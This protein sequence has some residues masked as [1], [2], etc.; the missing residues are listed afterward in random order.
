MALAAAAAV[1]AA[2]PTALE[3]RQDFFDRRP[4]SVPNRILK[5]WVGAK[6]NGL[7]LWLDF[8][9]DSMLVVSDNGPRIYPVNYAL[10]PRTLIIYGDTTLSHMLYHTFHR[11]HDDDEP[12]IPGYQFVIQHRFS[13]EKLLIEFDDVTITMTEQDYLARPL[14]ANWIADL[15]DG[16]QMQLYLDRS[17]S[18]SYRISPGG[19]R[20]FGEWDRTARDIDFDWT[21]DSLEVPDSTLIWTGFFDARNQQILLDSIGPGTSVTIF[22]RIIRR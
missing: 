17:G 5:R 6:V 22:R 14:E 19:S 12:F 4:D 7:P 15:A 21:P 8:F 10:T 16:T 18:A 20:V 9:G 3:A 11:V 1:L 2:A 13:L